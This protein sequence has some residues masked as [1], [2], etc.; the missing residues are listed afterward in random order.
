MNADASTLGKEWEKF[1]SSVVYF[2]LKL[3]TIQIQV[4]KEVRNDKPKSNFQLLEYT[5][6]ESTRN[7]Y[8]SKD[9]DK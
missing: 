6:D 4:T 1:V 2:N 3:E 5:D 8:S 7:T 9:I